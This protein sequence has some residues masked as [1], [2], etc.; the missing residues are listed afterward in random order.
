MNETADYK[1][2][3]PVMLHEHFCKEDILAVLK[4][5]KAERIF[6]AVGVLSFEP[7]KHNRM[8]EMLKKYVPYFQSNGL[9]V[10]IWFWSFWRSGLDVNELEDYLIV[11]TE[12]DMRSSGDTLEGEKKEGAGF[13][14][15]ASEKF[16]SSVTKTI[17]ELA[18]VHPDILMLDDDYRFGFHDLSMGCF[19]N[20]HMR[21]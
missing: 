5:C 11:N 18:S 10:G 20:A 15:P 3:I 13:C 4:A 19:C 7:E 1:I 12:G 16:L 2:S 17:A 6:L 21:L 8:M 14:C 9:E